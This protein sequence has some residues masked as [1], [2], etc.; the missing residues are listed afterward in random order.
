MQTAVLIF[1]IILT[2]TVFFESRIE[3]YIIGV[4]KKHV[5]KADCMYKLLTRHKMSRGVSGDQTIRSGMEQVKSAR[6]RDVLL[7]VG[8]VPLVKLLA[9]KTGWFS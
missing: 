9:H 7:G 2:H 4:L 8:K 1:V 3:N 5:V 6:Q